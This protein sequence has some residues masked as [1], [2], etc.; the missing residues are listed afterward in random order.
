MTL[1]KTGNIIL[2]EDEL[3]LQNLIRLNL[4]AEGYSVSVFSEGNQAIKNIHEIISK[5]LVILDV[6]LP[7]ISGLQICEK[8]REISSVPIL[9]LSA[10]GTTSD[11]I[12]GL[13]KGG[14]DYLVKPFDLEELL[15]KINILLSAQKAKDIVNR[16][17]IDEK[18]IDFD[19]YEVLNK[20][21]EILTTLSKKEIELLQFFISNNGKV[22]SRN[23]ILDKIWGIN[24]YPTSRTIDNFVLTFRKLFEKDSKSP[25]F[26]H[27]VRGVGYKFTN[28]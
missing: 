25:I 12:E 22:I 19:T 4:E 13:K 6:M 15:L 10:K 2:I 8:I 20:E 3:S 17:V 7:Q 14:T 23:E 16:Y 18:V 1:Q 5:D 21:G 24:Q 28:A 9:F 26:F 27:S 11:R